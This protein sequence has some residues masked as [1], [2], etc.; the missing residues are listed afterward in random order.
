[1]KHTLQLST[2]MGIATI[3]AL[4][5]F[6][7]WLV[8]FRPAP[9]PGAPA[10]A[11]RPAAFLNTEIQDQQGLKSPAL[12]AL[13]SKKGFSGG[14]P[15]AGIN[16]LMPSGEAGAGSLLPESSLREPEPP[17]YV[18]RKPAERESPDQVSLQEA[19]PE[20]KMELP[21]PATRPMS[22]VL[23]PKKIALFLSPELQTRTDEPLELKLSGTLPP[24][25]RVYLGIR[26]DG[27]VDQVL[28]GTPVE[29]SALAG[30]IRKLRFK[31]AARRTDSWLDLRFTP[32]G[33]S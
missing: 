10:P 20:L 13:P 27:T 12:F 16:L 18:A 11:A 23:Q 2:A 19:I 30:A 7:L 26:P 32:G 17:R 15:E 28:F 8:P 14:F 21:A 24:S 6:A 3:F 22:S 29:N 33:T 1:V 4:L 25:V 5:W 9:P 31:P